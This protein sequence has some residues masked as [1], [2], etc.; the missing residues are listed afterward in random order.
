MASH[1]DERLS[2]RAVFGP[3][4]PTVRLTIQGM[5]CDGCASRVEENLQQVSGVQSAAA[6]HEQG[7][8]E[9]S[10]VAGEGDADAIRGTVEELGYEVTGLQGT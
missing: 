4:M 2:P 9:L 6:D 8:A 3:T 5:M 1:E 7:T 10:V